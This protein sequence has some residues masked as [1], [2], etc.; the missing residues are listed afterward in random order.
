MGADAT[1]IG[2][3]C[4]FRLEPPPSDDPLPDMGT[5]RCRTVSPPAESVR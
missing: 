5:I 1:W 2:G 4:K 3:R